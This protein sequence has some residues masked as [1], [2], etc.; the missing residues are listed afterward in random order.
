V[1]RRFQAVARRS[2]ALV[3]RGRIER[4]DGATNLAAEHLAPLSLKVSTTS[5][6]FR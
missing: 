3:V 4:A 1:W 2:P 5:R 6:D